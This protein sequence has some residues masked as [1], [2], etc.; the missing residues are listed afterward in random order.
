MTRSLL[1]CLLLLAACRQQAPLPEL[2]TWPE[3][4]LLTGAAHP[5]RLGTGSTDLALAD[6]FGPGFEA[7]SVHLPEGFLGR[8]TRTRVG[9]TAGKGSPPVGRMTVFKDG[10]GYVI[11]VL[12]SPARAVELAYR[13]KDGGTPGRVAVAGVFNDWNPVA[14]PMT[15]EGDAWK[16]TLYLVPGR[17]AYQLVVDGVWGLDPANPDSLD[18][19]IGGYNSVLNV[20]QQPGRPFLRPA[21]EGP[22]GMEVTLEGNADNWLVLWNYTELD[23]R[24]VE[25]TDAGLRIRPPARSRAADGGVLTLLAWN[26]E[27]RSND[28]RIP[29][30]GGRPVEAAGVRPSAEGP[31][32]WGDQ[33]IYFPL[34]DRFANGEPANDAPTDDPR[35][36]PP[37]NFFGGD[38]QGLRAHL[39]HIEGLGV[40]TLWVSPVARNPEGAF[41]EYPEPRRWFSGYHGYWPVSYRQ[42]DPRFGGD[43]A[44]EALVREAH[45]RGMRVL[46]DFVANHVHEQH[47]MLAAHPDWTTDL[48]LPDG[49][50][51]LRLWDEQR[52]T[53]WF[54]DFLPSLDLENPAV[55]EAVT[56]SAVWWIGRFDLDGFRHDATKHIPEAFQHA[57]TAKLKAAYP[58]RR[59]YQIGET[60]GSRELIARYLG[61]GLLDAQF[62]FP[63]YFATRSVLTAPDGDF[64]TLADELSASLE[65]Y[66]HHHAMGNITGNHDMA[67]FGS[68][69]GGGLAPGEDPK[70]AGW[71]RT[72]GLGDTALALERLALLTGFNAAV[73]GVP[74]IY[75]GDE[76][77]LAGGGDPDSRRMM[78]F[79][80]WRP[81][82]Q[83][84]YEAVGAQLAARAASPALRLG[85]TEV[86][87][88]G[89]DHLV[90]RRSWFGDQRL[91]VL[92]KGAAPRTV[93]LPAGTAPAS[94]ED[95]LLA[96]EGSAVEGAALRAAPGASYLR[97]RPAASAKGH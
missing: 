20:A 59:L 70:E 46:L 47:P 4:P 29:L 89:P 72:V 61:P 65:A 31:V 37:A 91:V 24:F 10:F 75:Y 54:D 8:A 55:V 16:T 60:F 58:D 97:L 52:L 11:P 41:R 1:P 9:L 84:L 78:V 66:G 34:V 93:A 36:L 48:D 38:L 53:T 27:G 76:I 68:L 73:P 82:Q 56:D 96:P 81:D 13:P 33:T 5:A 45:A 32:R 90:L 62:D 92:N 79:E 30:S 26:A 80:G 87:D 18:N 40:N 6:W 69:A 88:A 86:L 51:N 22:D 95:A 23:E 2:D 50:R 49:R 3:T 39:D 43:A 7:D 63:L 57:L 67:R 21:A 15:R 17:Y 74:V 42:V 77:G 25:R 85:T 94:G 14:S 83:G 28:L 71:H 35:V 44:L 12:R 19:N 64:R